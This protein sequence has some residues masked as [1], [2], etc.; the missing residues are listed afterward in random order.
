MDQPSVDLPDTKTAVIA[1][2]D[3]GLCYR[4]IAE[5]LATTKGAVAGI[6]HRERLSRM[7][8]EDHE[9][10][11]EIRL[12]TRRDMK[13]PVPTPKRVVNDT[14]PPETPVPIRVLLPVPVEIT[15]DPISFSL[16]G[17][18]RCRWPL[19]SAEEPLPGKALCGAACGRETYCAGHAA[20]A[21]RPARDRRAA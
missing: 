20:M 6:V 18:G 13:R 9:K 10:A 1:L 7:S 14:P 17:P 5:R 8:L 16:V 4:E 21:Y 15:S 3:A 11:K 12:A 19:W 2:L